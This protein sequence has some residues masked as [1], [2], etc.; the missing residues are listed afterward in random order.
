MP[1]SLWPHPPKKDDSDFDE[2]MLELHNRLFGIESGGGDL[3]SDN[4]AV[5]VGGSNDRQDH[6]NTQLA[7]TISNFDVSVIAEHNSISGGHSLL[8]QAVDQSDSS[9]S[10]LSITNPNADAT[11]GT[12]E[13]D[14]INEIKAD[15]NTLIGQLN[16]FVGDYNALLA[17]MRTAG[18]LV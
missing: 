7:S 6:F 17:V 15:F 8:K 14:L 11:Y 5:S 3:D 9:T 18:I 1:D 4:V 2:Y 10:G 13:R 12:E 16:T